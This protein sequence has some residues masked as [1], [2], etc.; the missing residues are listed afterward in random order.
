MLCANL[1]VQKKLRLLSIVQVAAYH[2]DDIFGLAQ[3]NEVYMLN[4]A[5]MPEGKKWYARLLFAFV[6]GRFHFSC[7]TQFLLSLLFF[8][9][10]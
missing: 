10:R 7:C 6:N 8:F 1:R 3:P 2:L 4:L 5:F 9:E